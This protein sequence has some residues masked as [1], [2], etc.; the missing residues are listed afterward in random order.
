LLACANVL[1]GFAPG[2]RLPPFAHAS[3]PG[4]PMLTAADPGKRTSGPR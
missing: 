1:F 3:K 2:D 4:A